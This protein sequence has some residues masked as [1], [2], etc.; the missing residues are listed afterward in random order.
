M[1]KKQKREWAINKAVSVLT[2]NN[3]IEIFK[4]GELHDKLEEI[5]DRQELGLIICTENSPEGAMKWQELVG[6]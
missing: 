2:Q 5:A 6:A 3:P 4:L 1:T